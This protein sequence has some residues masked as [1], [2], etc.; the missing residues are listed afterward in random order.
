MKRAPH[1]LKRRWIFS[2]GLVALA[3]YALGC[4]TSPPTPPAT[5]GAGVDQPSPASQELREIRLVED[6]G[7]LNVV[8]AGSDALRYTAFKAIDPL[9]LV[10]D[11]PNTEARGVPSPLL[12]ERG[13]VDKIE[14]AV[15]TRDPQPLTRVEIGLKQETA[16]EISAEQDGIRVRFEPEPPLMEAKATEAELANTP[17]ADNI[18][19]G[20]QAKQE[21]L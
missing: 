6:Q 20:V 4:A 15:V 16:Y 9:R 18:G 11:L 3:L 2:M 8:L 10:V 17:P 14:T 12:V 1:H 19:R 7:S 21:A 5:Q 13:V